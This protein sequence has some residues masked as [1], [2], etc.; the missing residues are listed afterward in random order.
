MLR[1]DQRKTKAEGV[2]LSRI[3]YCLEVVSQGRKADL[4]R[5]QSVQSKA[6]RWVLQTRKQD[7]SLSGGLRKLQWLSMAQQA[8]FVSIKLVMKVIKKHNPERIYDILTEEREGIRKVRSVDKKC[9]G[10]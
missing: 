9:S 5:L 10:N 4:E 2:I 7:W 8:A 1:Q 3:S 6:A